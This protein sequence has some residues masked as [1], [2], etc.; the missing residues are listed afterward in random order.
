MEDG[1]VRAQTPELKVEEQTPLP[2]PKG[3][4]TYT[5]LD[6]YE[7]V[8]PN[9]VPGIT[10][11]K[12]DT[13]LMQGD[14]K[15]P[16]RIVVLENTGPKELTLRYM[17]VAEGKQ[18]KGLGASQMEDAV[19]LAE[20]TGRTIH[21]DVSFTKAAIGTFEKLFREGRLKAAEPPDFE[22]MKKLA[23]ENGGVAKNPSG[24]PWIKDMRLGN[25]E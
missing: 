21:A 22:R 19:D 23:E 13:V 18:G 1:P 24:E 10:T 3:Q 15:N 7:G 20:S 6:V 9:V 5:G 8:E 17:R 2:K 25:M 11:R 4:K 12:G 14:P 16:D